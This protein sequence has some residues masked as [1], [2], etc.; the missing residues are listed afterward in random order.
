MQLTVATNLTDL[1]RE[2][3]FLSEMLTQ[4]LNGMTMEVLEE[5]ENGAA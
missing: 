5:Q 2:P 4:I 3:S 1:H